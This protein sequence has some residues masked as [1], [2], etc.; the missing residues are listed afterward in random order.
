MK[1]T[2]EKASDGRNRPDRDHIVELETLEDLLEWVRDSGVAV[3][4]KA[5]AGNINRDPGPHLM[6]YDDYIE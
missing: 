2:W 1:F 6:V 4:I 5:E 3:I